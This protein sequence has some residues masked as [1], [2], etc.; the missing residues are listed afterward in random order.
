MLLLRQLFSAVIYECALLKICF[1]RVT[2]FRQMLVQRFM[3][4]LVKIHCFQRVA[5]EASVLCNL[6]LVFNNL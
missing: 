3:N 4:G 2:A 6:L 5:Y 1:G